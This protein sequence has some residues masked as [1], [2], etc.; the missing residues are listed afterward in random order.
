MAL[1]VIWNL[2]SFS[3]STFSPSSLFIFLFYSLHNQPTNQP[4]FT[5]FPVPVQLIS[6]FKR[7]QGTGKKAKKCSCQVLNVVTLLNINHFTV[8]WEYICNLNN[9]NGGSVLLITLLRYMYHVC[10]RLEIWIYTWLCRCGTIPVCPNLWGL[11]WW[12]YIY[13]STNTAK[14]TQYYYQTNSDSELNWIESNVSICIQKSPNNQF[15]K[16][17]KPTYR[18]P[19]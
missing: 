7:N 16:S 3:S 11:F 12:R 18:I 8:G 6:S 17:V 15:S 5:W 1:C 2:I 13:V 19:H 4:T 14:A 9:S 10:N